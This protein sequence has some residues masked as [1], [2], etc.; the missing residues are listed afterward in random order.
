VMLV[1]MLARRGTPN[2]SLSRG[3]EADFG[4]KR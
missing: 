1:Q 3:G 4:L 2:A